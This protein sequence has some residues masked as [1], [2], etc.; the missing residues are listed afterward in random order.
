MFP[1]TNFGQI[2]NYSRIDQQLMSNLQAPSINKKSLGQR[3]KGHV[4]LI[5][6]NIIMGVT[7]LTEMIIMKLFMLLSMILLLI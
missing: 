2:K 1:L 3:S 7:C 5:E 4:K 6:Y